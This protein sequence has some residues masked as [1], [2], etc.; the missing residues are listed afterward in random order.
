MSV[1]PCKKFRT[2]LESDLKLN[3]TYSL[4]SRLDR[5]EFNKTRRKMFSNRLPRSINV[6]KRKKKEGTKE[7]KRRKEVKKKEIKIERSKRKK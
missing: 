3:T 7:R 5:Y 2:G 6:V 4:S 1:Q